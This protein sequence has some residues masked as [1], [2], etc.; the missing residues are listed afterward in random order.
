MGSGEMVEV[1]VII[2]GKTKSGKAYIV[3]E[4]LNSETFFLP[5]SQC[6][7]IE[8]L[9]PNNHNDKEYLMEI[10]AWLAKEKELI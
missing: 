1:F 10:P 6:Y 3:K 2:E 8:K 5:V 7:N 4:D 9:K